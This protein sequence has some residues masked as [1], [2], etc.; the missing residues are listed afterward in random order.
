MDGAAKTG[1]LQD[2]V[3]AP[4]DFT[5]FVELNVG[6]DTTVLDRERR[7]SLRSVIHET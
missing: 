3:L 6:L 4:N 5:R 7:E 2:M 1:D